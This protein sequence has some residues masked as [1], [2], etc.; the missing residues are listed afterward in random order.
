MSSCD[1]ICIELPALVTGELNHA[2][3]AT[4]EG[5]LVSC[6]HCRRELAETRKV[7]GLVSRAPLE[8]APPWHSRKRRLH[9]PGTRAGG[10]RGPGGS[11]RARTA[12]DPRAEVDG[13]RRRRRAGTDPLAAHLRLP[14]PR[15]RRLPAHRGLSR[16]L[17]R[18]R[19]SGRGRFGSG[20]WPV[21]LGCDQHHLHRDLGPTPSGRRSTAPLRRD[22][23]EPTRSP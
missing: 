14:R 4:V 2:Q 10:R 19:G 5:H 15:A 8:H 12:C 18:R 3:S 20:C 6:D 11:A 23:M 9:L 13:A 21:L 1:A 17:V 7:I 16:L 22:P